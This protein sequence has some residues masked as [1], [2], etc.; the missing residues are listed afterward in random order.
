MPDGRDSLWIC[1]VGH[2]TLLAIV[3]VGVHRVK[4]T[5]CR[6]IIR[7][8]ALFAVSVPADGGGMG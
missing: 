4:A 2:F 6:V 1:T 8:E 3:R 7:E 5:S